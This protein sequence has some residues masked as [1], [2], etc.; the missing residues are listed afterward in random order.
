M[1]FEVFNIS[2]SIGWGG[3]IDWFLSHFYFSKFVE[4]QSIDPECQLIGSLKFSTI[5]IQKVC[6]IDCNALSIDWSC[7]NHIF[8]KTKGLCNRLV[9]GTNRLVHSYFQ[10]SNSQNTMS[11]VIPFL[12]KHHFF[13]QQNP[14][15]YMFLYTFNSR[16]PSS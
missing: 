2:Q 12:I 16:I 1:D 10:I 5:H 13:F 6:A 7:K 11:S 15:Y 3:P 8:C 9:T 14:S 4:D